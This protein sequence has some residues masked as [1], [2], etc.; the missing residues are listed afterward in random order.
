MDFKNER[1]RMTAKLLTEFSLDEI[2]ELPYSDIEKLHKLKKEK[3]SLVSALKHE[4]SNE[5]L[6]SSSVQDLRR[7]AEKVETVTLEYESEVEEEIVEDIDGAFAGIR[8][9]TRIIK[10]DFRQRFSGLINLYSIVKQ[11]L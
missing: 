3:E 2:E 6:E 10:D 5:D 11:K 1:K 8:N 7:L 4:F 9:L